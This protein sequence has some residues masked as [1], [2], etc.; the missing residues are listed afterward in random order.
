MTDALVLLSG[1]GASHTKTEA[2]EATN[3]QLSTLTRTAPQA[4]FPTTRRE[5]RR[6]LRGL[7][8][9][10]RAIVGAKLATGAWEYRPSPAE[11]AEI[12]QTHARL[13]HAALGRS[14]KAL[15]DAELDRL[16]E[17]IGPDRIWRAVDRLTS[18][19]LP[20]ATAAE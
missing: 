8:P 14:P 6:Q 1:K 12:V 17:R 7:S 3:M 10:L 19:T 18:P 5:L 15:T 9:Q 4:D 2:E 11:A 16:I 13:I 20:F